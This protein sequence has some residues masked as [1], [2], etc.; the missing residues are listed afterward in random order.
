MVIRRLSVVLLLL[1][2]YGIAWAQ[3]DQGGE[4]CANAVQIFNLPYQDNGLTGQADNCVGQPFRDVFYQFTATTSGQYTAGMCG[5]PTNGYLKIW[6]QNSCCNALLFSA[7]AGCG[8]DPFISFPLLAGAAIIIECGSAT[9]TGTPEPYVFQLSGTPNPQCAGTIQIAPQTMQFPPT[10]VGALSQLVVAVTNNGTQNLCVDSVRTNGQIWSVSP[11]S[12]QIPPSASQ[13]VTVTF[14]PTFAHDFLGTVEI[15]SSD[16]VRPRDSVLV[17][18]AGCRPVTNPPAPILM[19]AASPTDVYFRMPWIAGSASIEYAIEFSSDG[20]GSSEFVRWPYGVSMDPDYATASQWGIGGGGTISGLTPGT[21]YSVRLRARDCTG[22][23]VIS[24]AASIQTE[25]TI[26]MEFVPLTLHSVSSALVELNWDTIPRDTSGRPLSNDGWEVLLGSNPDNVDS[27]VAVTNTSPFVIPTEG[28]TKAFFAVEPRVSAFYDPPR[29]FISW[30][31]DGATLAGRHAIVIHDLLHLAEWDSFRIEADS[32]GWPVLLGSNLD[33]PQDATGF[34]GCEYD[35]SALG[36]G[37]HLVTASLVDRQGRTWVSN[38]NVNVVQEPYATYD[39]VWNPARGI[40]VMQTQGVTS[41]SPIADFL[42]LSSHVNERYGSETTIEW[43]PD[44]D[45][46]TIVK[47]IPQLASDL[48]MWNPDYWF[49]VPGETAG[50]QPAPEGTT[51]P[52]TQIGCCC[53]EL[54]IS[55]AGD[56]EGQY[57]GNRGKLGP[58]VECLPSGQ[59]T[60]AFGFEVNITLRCDVE[61]ASF[62]QGQDAKGT[63]TISTGTCKSGF[64]CEL[65]DSTRRYQNDNEAHAFDGT[66]GNDG[67]GVIEKGKSPR[68][69][70]YRDESDRPGNPKRRNPRATGVTRWYDYPG[71]TINRDDRPLSQ[72]GCVNLRGDNSFR[73]QATPPCDAAE[74]C[75]KEFETHYNVTLC[76]RQGICEPTSHTAPY[77]TEPTTPEGGCPP[78]A[79]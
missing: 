56:A 47:V 65:K 19:T 50:V 78:L 67:N 53:E 21:V 59:Y 45:S 3:L 40:F 27:V 79:P 55:T 4:T 12:F 77:M 22:T 66:Y 24:S 29:P 25:P 72:H 1:F 49:H 34:R 8:D 73:V 71:E 23:E 6:P 2:A 26:E 70:G 30:P 17:S 44:F 11:S 10:Y 76:K 5:S 75:C 33:N 51:Q 74:P 36:D 37:S 32:M 63:R 61:G 42:W 16:P 43:Y 14:A 7:D 69:R 57:G 62:Q 60:V 38:I 54:T 68:N 52:I 18:G 13:P 20:F 64:V 58:I 35:F 39:A 9:P 28:I 48:V 46:L 31:P 15:F 41:P